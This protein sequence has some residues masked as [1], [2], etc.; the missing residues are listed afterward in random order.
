MSTCHRI[1]TYKTTETKSWEQEGGWPD[2]SQPPDSVTTTPKDL[3]DYSN[4]CPPL[5]PG[6]ACPEGMYVP[7]GDVPYVQTQTYA[8]SKTWVELEPEIPHIKTYHV[9]HIKT[10]IEV[11]DEMRT[12]ACLDPNTWKQFESVLKDFFPSQEPKPTLLAN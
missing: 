5:C 1:L 11:T 7:L 9:E 8:T 12:W 4:H 2:T 10:T 3:V 6:F